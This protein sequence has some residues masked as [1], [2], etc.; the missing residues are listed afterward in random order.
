MVKWRP[1]CLSSQAFIPHS[2]C[3]D[4]RISWDLMGSV[5]KGKILSYTIFTFSFVLLFW[6]ALDF[7]MP[8][9]L[10]CVPYS[11]THNL[12]YSIL[13]PPSLVHLLSSITSLLYH[14]HSHPPFS[15]TLS[16]LLSISLSSNSLPLHSILFLSSQHPFITP[17]LPVLTS[18]T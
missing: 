3:T 12:H 6:L 9:H 13:H 17:C 14:P 16:P 15:I 8:Q 4:H 5:P 10:F 11:I 7:V 2:A 18:S 1:F